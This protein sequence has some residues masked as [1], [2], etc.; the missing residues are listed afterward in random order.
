MVS[1]VTETRCAKSSRNATAA[2]SKPVPPRSATVSAPYV[3]PRAL[4]A[5]VS[6]STGR[7][8]ASASRSGRAGTAEASAGSECSPS[9]TM[10][11]SEAP[12]ATTRPRL[13]EGSTAPTGRDAACTPPSARR[14][15][16]E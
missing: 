3:V 8:V 15:R 1:S 9:G 4:S 12:V 11:R 2:S 16:K 10:T 14:A 13:E 6:M 7:I 5:I